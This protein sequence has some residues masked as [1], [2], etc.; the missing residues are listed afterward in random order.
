MDEPSPEQLCAIFAAI[1]DREMAQLRASIAAL[2]AAQASALAA[3]ES[4]SQYGFDYLE[5]PNPSQDKP[6]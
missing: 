1:N 6:A 4:L 3:S 5:Y 2:K